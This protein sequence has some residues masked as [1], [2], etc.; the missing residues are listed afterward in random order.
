MHTIASL[1]RV[2]DIYLDLAVSAKN[3][4]LDVIGRRLETSRGL[5]HDFI[6][7]GLQRREA[8]G[9]TALG[10]G[11]AIPHAR[12]K[13]LE[14]IVVSYAHLRSPI[15]FD[16]PDGLPVSDILIL[17]VPKQ[18]TEEHLRILAEATQLFSARDFRQRLR[19][20]R[21]SADV[22]ALFDSWHD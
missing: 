14:E 22:K 5:P 15:P 16:A 9:S 3:E 6:T 10:Q 21:T 8:V 1:L 7:S 4:L 20:C 19:D 2:E 13:D 18:A 11:V 17:L 12:V